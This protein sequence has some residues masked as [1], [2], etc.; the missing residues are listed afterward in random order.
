[1]RV[2]QCLHSIGLDDLKALDM[3]QRKIHVKEVETLRKKLIL[4]K[5]IKC[6]MYGPLLC[7]FNVPV[8]G[9]S[10]LVS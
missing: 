6:L 8:N 4:L 5:S 2:K 9:L 7:G 3:Q 1:V 10:V